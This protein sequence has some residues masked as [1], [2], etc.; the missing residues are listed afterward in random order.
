LQT[1]LEQAMTR[2]ITIARLLCIAI[3]GV[4]TGTSAGAALAQSWPVKPIRVVIPFGAGSA[5]DVI[6]R[7]VLEQLSQQLGQP[8]IVENRA[9]AGS[10]TGTAAVAKAEPDGYTL[11][12]TSA[13]YSNGP[14]L[15]ASLPYDPIKDL[16]AVIPIANSPSALI[17]PASR[18]FKTAAD[19]VAAAKAKPGSFNF[20][21]VG[22]GSAVHL[23]AEKFRLAAGFEAAHVPFKSGAEALSEIVAGRI[24]FYMCP[25]GTALPMI[26][27]GKVTALAV[28]SPKRSV[29]LPDVPTTEEQG[30]KGSATSV[31][32]GLLAPA[33]V[34][35]AILDKLYKEMEKALAA[36]SVQ[37]KYAQNG[38][39]PLPL[40]S[41]QFAAQIGREIEEVKALAKAL[42]LKAN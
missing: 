29:A 36:P 33:K 15:Y 26:K 27:D 3:S 16:V 40:T 21:S 38:V 7:I 17:V 11:L 39:E 18:G 10:V 8:V 41:A 13:A 23:M 25:I 31:W 24:D 14:A 12:V 5:V 30:Y 34:P 32:L 6:P 19:M 42:N 28:A 4:L 37:Q 9:G 2:R 20:A 22:A 1:S 35:P